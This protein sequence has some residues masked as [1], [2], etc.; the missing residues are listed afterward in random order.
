MTDAADSLTGAPE[1]GGGSP[2]GGLGGRVARGAAWIAGG[3]FALRVLGL[4]NTL[5]VA[6]LLAP[7]DFGVVAI[8][9]TLTQLL[10][11][12]SDVGVSQAV[13]RYDKAGRRELD[14]LFTLSTFRGVLISGLLLI[15]SIGASSFFDDARVGPIFAVMAV[16]AF[17]QSLYNPKFYEFHRAISFRQEMTVL[18]I[19]KIVMAGSSIAMAL[20]FRTYWAIVLSI[21]LGALVRVALT[22]VLRPYM[23][24]F[25]LSAFRE[26]ISFTGWITG[27]G[28]I[29]ALN[30][31]LS[32]LVLGRLLGPTLTGVYS[33]GSTIAYL[34]GS[35]IAE[36]VAR[37][38]Y[39]GLSSLKDQSERMRTALLKGMAALGAVALPASVG[40]A[41]VA[42]DLV[43]VLLGQNWAASVFVVQVY[44]P[45]VGVTAVVHL[46]SDY[47]VAKGEARRACIREAIYFLIRFPA[48]VWATATF[49]FTGAVW[50]AAGSGVLL[51]VLNGWLYSQLTGRSALDIVRALWRPTLAVTAMAGFF[52]LA[53]P[54]MPG[55]DEAPAIVRLLVD[56]AMGAAVYG[57]ALLLIWRASG[58]P[59]GPERSLLSAIRARA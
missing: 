2:P 27:L 15:A 59:D 13:V 23:P 22:Y 36:P 6:R 4:L 20:A 18:T 58:A 45:T 11:N 51:A 31:K 5:V 17:V 39:P 14:T 10:Q 48:F 8:G 57:L 47:A 24:R 12:F 7:D 26:M 28:F 1:D 38:I 16:V 50:S 3:Y 37:A 56:A 35:D 41:F 44:A 9:V 53:H 30:N 49:G 42:H 25:G 21:L 29:V 19:E 46:V 52:F 43:E 32:P 34:P 54:L 55:F 40:C 33:L